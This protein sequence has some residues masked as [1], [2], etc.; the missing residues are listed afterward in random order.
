MWLRAEGSCTSRAGDDPHVPLLVGLKNRTR[1]RGREL[2]PVCGAVAA[3]RA[4]F[5]D[6]ID[7]G[8]CVIVF[9]SNGW[10]IAG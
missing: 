4:Y 9:S 8:V 7:L 5:A 1:H 6:Q 3:Q 2:A 10:I